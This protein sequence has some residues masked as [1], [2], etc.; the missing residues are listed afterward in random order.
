MSMQ[1]AERY[2][3]TSLDSTFGEA[4]VQPYLPFVLADQNQT[5]T[6]SGLLDTG[7]MINVLPYRIG[8]ELGAIWE[9][10]TTAVK[11]T[12]NLAQVEARALVVT[13][14]VGKFEPVK[15]AFAWTQTEAV[16]LLLGQVNFFL[17]FDVCFYRSQK[18][19]DICPKAVST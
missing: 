2:L 5:V 10:Q 3:F 15:L 18:A 9:H 7:A 19:F 16:P 11:L 4:S 8:I 6:A 14:I 12:G 1:H 13:A 17:E